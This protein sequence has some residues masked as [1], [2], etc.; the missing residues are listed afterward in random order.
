MAIWVQGQFFGADTEAEVTA[1]GTLVP[2]ALYWCK[3][4]R[5][6]LFADT[7]STSKGVGEGLTIEARTDDPGSPATGQIWLRTDL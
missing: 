3:D 6:I 2:G 1:L 5:R 4:T 7:S